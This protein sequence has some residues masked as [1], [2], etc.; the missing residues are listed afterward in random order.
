MT[1]E[2]WGSVRVGSLVRCA[3]KFPEDD[4]LAIFA[5]AGGQHREHWIFHWLDENETSEESK[6][7]STH[8]RESLHLVSR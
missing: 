7:Y 1:A 5:G 4:C 3:W 8:V 2:E 6:L